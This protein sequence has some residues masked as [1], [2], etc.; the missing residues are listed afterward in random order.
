MNNYFASPVSRAIER[1]HSREMCDF[2]DYF[3]ESYPEEESYD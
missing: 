3:P 1:E 2:P